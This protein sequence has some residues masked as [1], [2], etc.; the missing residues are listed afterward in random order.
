MKIPMKDSRR[1]A[2]VRI[3]HPLRLPVQTMR[4][5]AVFRKVPEGYIAFAEE[6]PGANAQEPTLARTRRS[7]KEAVGLVLEANRMLAEEAVSGEKVI[8]ETLQLEAR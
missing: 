7:L 5:T 3:K 4:F 2:K 6:V 1:K 8:R